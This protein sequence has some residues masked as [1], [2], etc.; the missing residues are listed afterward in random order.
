MTDH[1][2]N[3][4]VPPEPDVELTNQGSIF[5]FQPL[6]AA[7]FEWIR[8]NIPDDAQYF[9][10]ALAVESRYAPTVAQGMV[11]DGLCLMTD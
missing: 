2:S 9:G 11:D 5:T 10:S 8:E 7:A 1:N 3:K 4:L 6:T